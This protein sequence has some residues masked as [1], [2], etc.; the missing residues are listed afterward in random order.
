VCQGNL[1]ISSQTV[2]GAVHLH[3]KK[4]V[5]DEEASRCEPCGQWEPDCTDGLKD[6]PRE[7]QE[8]GH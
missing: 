3:R 1:F 8:G 6:P 7:V 2:H 5:S 4:R